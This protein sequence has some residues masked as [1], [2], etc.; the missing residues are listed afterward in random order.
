LKG[1][2][3]GIEEVHHRSESLVKECKTI[4]VGMGIWRVFVPFAHFDE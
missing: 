1:I 4:V 3:G 2:G